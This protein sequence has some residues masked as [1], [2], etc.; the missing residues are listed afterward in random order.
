MSDIN[1]KIVKKKDS[2]KTKSHRKKSIKSSKNKENAKNDNLMLTKIE[3]FI[4]IDKKNEHFKDE[5]CIL[6]NLNKLFLN[7]NET[8]SSNLIGYTIDGKRNTVIKFNRSPTT[9]AIEKFTFPTKEKEKNNNL[10]ISNKRNDVKSKSKRRSSLIYS[11]NFIDKIEL[12][13]MTENTDNKENITLMK[14]F[15]DNY[16]SE[17]DEKHKSKKMN[18]NVTR[19]LNKDTKEHILKNTMLVKHSNLNNILEFE[20]NLKSLNK[21][22]KELKSKRKQKSKKDE[23]IKKEEKNIS[24]ENNKNKEKEILK[25]D[26][27]N[28]IIPKRREN[29]SKTRKQRRVS[30]HCGNLQKNMIKE[31]NQNYLLNNNNIKK[32]EITKKSENDEEKVNKNFVRKRSKSKHINRKSSLHN[33]HF[34]FD[35]DLKLKKPKDNK[36]KL[37]Q[38]VL[39]PKKS[40][41]LEPKNKDKE[42]NEN[43]DYYTN[44]NDKSKI[45]I[46]SSSDSVKT[47]KKSK[48]KKKKNQMNL[49]MHKKESIKNVHHSI[50]NTS[51]YSNLVLNDSSQIKGNN[52][53]RN[54]IKNLFEYKMKHVNHFCIKS[55]NKINRN[56]SSIIKLPFFSVVKPDKLVSIEYT[57]AYENNNRSFCL[58][59]VSEDKLTREHKNND[60]NE[61]ED[62]KVEKRNKSFFCCL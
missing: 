46:S 7:D 25:Q 53:Y 15:K 20:S 45:N 33:Y 24:E 56:K 38:S 62:Y 27:N 40:S 49:K 12:N 50:V 58:N 35:K 52:F 39:F 57:R 34:D 5:T 48:S 26:S 43:S 14:K 61:N 4:E 8:G 60:R 11:K 28:Y 3:E 36:S 42:E 23:K 6:K 1:E 31:I 17:D 19:K 13:N 16:Q 41:L 44:N 29:K 18:S 22:G 54:N 9:L 37:F 32:L 59:K 51:N 30:F 55:L 21:A 47:V 10:Q 2:L